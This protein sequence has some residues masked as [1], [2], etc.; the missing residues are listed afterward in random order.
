MIFCFEC[1]WYVVYIYEVEINE[2]FDLVIVVFGLCFDF[3][4]SFYWE[5]S[6]VVKYFVFIG[7]WK[8]RFLFIVVDIILFLLGILME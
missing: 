1:Y 4:K 8:F 3:C 5:C 7:K 6:D 2:N